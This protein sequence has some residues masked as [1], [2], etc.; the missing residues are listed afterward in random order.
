MERTIGELAGHK[1]I[2]VMGALQNDSPAGVF[3]Y[4]VVVLQLSEHTVICRWTDDVEIDYEVHERE[5]ALPEVEGCT[6]V[7]LVSDLIQDPTGE[8]VSFT[9]ECP[10]NQGYMDMLMFA[11]DRVQP[12][13]GI[14]A[15]PA[16]LEIFTVGIH[17]P[18]VP[19]AA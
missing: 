13:F 17:K 9:W 18:D 5:R 6:W 12:S 19:G 7:P 3:W 4:D 14:L 16:S 2:A 8:W 1:L 15:S 11:L 10:N